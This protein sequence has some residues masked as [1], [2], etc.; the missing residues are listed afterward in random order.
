MSLGSRALFLRLPSTVCL[1]TQSGRHTC[2]HEL[3]PDDVHGGCT[4]LEFHSHMSL[5][6]ELYNPLL[7]IWGKRLYVEICSF[8]SHLLTLSCF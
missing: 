2:F 6:S 5:D 8:N 3:L 4:H 7:Y 1:L